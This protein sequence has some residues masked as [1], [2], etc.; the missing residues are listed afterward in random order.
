MPH[1]KETEGAP[2]T[3]RTGRSPLSPISG[4]PAPL[5]LSLSFINL[6]E[7]LQSETR[8][9]LEALA[10]IGRAV[11]KL[12][13]YIEFHDV[14]RQ[15]FRQTVEGTLKPDVEKKLRQLGVRT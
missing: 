13:E 15:L 7:Y 12:Y 3:P 6:K 2:L 8:E 10:A 5:L 11:D 9:I 14:S 4:I 1:T